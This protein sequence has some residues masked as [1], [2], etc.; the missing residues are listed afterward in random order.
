MNNTYKLVVASQK[1]GVGKT[2]I[3]VNLAVAL[4]LMGYRVLLMDLDYSN[5]SVGFHL[6]L[7]D[8]NAGLRAVLAHKVKAKNAIVVHSPTGLHVLSCET[9]VNPGIPNFA[10]LRS[11]LLEV[12]KMDYDFVIKDTPPG[13]VPLELF[14]TF[15]GVD[16]LDVLT[17]IMPTNASCASAIRL[18]KAIAPLRLDHKYVVNHERYKPYE[19]SVREIEDAT[20]DSIY[21]AFPEDETVPEGIASHIPA[22]M[23]KPRCEFSR[24]VRELARHYASKSGISPMERGS[25]K[26]RGFNRMSFW[27]RLR[28][29]FNGRDI[30][31]E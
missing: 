15:K 13:P 12:N 30:E 21:A 14:K 3:A 6:G 18:T 8:V 26:L 17:V 1:G 11:T 10:N 7:E 4:R 31:D 16:N 29:L 5:P 28:L 27:G 24:E 2:T 25:P 23:L 22:Y 20:G 19:L 9:G